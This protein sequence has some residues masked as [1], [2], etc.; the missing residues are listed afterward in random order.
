MLLFSGS[1]P[2]R[3]QVGG[4][5]T[6]LS[7]SRNC[8]ENTRKAGIS[9]SAL[10]VLVLLLGLV[11]TSFTHAFSDDFSS[12]TA[13]NY[14]VVDIW[15]QS[16]V[17]SFAVDAASQ[18]GQILTGDNIGIQVGQSFPAVDTSSFSLDFSPTAIYPSGGIVRIRLRENASTYYEIENTDG[19]GPGTVEKVVGGSVV[20]SGTFG[21]EF[22]FGSSY[23]LTIDFSPT[24]V[25]VSGFGADV[26]VGG[27]STPINVS[28]VEIEFLQL[29][30]FI[31]NLQLGP[32]VPVPAQ[33]NI[34]SPADNTTSG[35]ADVSIA[36]GTQGQAGDFD[37]IQVQLDAQ[38]PISLTPAATSYTFFGLADGA[39]TVVVRLLSNGVALP[40]PE[41]S[42]SVDFDVL[43][44]QAPPTAFSDDFSANTISSYSQVASN[45]VA[46]MIY[47]AA[48]Q[49][50]LL[51][52][53]DNVSLSVTRAFEGSTNTGV[54][55]FEFA[56]IALYP[57]G[58]VLNVRLIQD[59]NNY[60][61][62][63]NTDGYGAGEIEKVVGGVVVATQPFGGE[64][65]I[66]ALYNLSLTFSPTEFH[67]E[68]FGAPV[69]VAGNTTPI[70]VG[71]VEFNFSQLDGYIDDLSL[72]AEI[73]V[74][75]PQVTI[76]QPS[77]GAVLAADDVRV[78]FNAQAPAGSFDEI[79]VQLDAQA[80]VSL[81][82]TQTEY[83]FS[84]VANGAHSVAVRLLLAGAPLGNA[85]ASDSSNFTVNVVPVAP[86]AEAGPNQ[87]VVQGETVNLTS[88]G[89]S[90]DGAIVSYLWRQTAGSENL[91]FDS[92]SATP[93]FTA[94]SV[95]GG[96]EQYTFELTVTDN[97][98]LTGQ[99]TVTVTVRSDQVSFSDDF[100]ANSVA[101]YSQSPTNPVAELIFDS[102][103]QRGFVQTADN[104]ALIISR[105]FGVS[106]DTGV[107]TMD[108]SP[109]ALYPRGA[110]LNLRLVQDANNY[111]E[112]RNT[113]GYGA[114]DIDKVVGG[115]VVASQPFTGEFSIGQNYTLTLTFSPDDFVVG[116]FGPDV[117]A[118]DSAGTS[119]NVQSFEIEF[120]QL[121]G[122]IDNINLSAEIPLPV[123]QVS[124]NQPAQGA[125]LA[126]DSVLVTFNTIAEAGAF[127]EIEVQ[128]DSGTPVSLS[129]MD[130]QYTFANVANGA[131]T[132]TVQ[133][134]LAGTALANVEAQDSVNFNVNVVPLAPTAEAGPNQNVVQGDAVNLSSAG[135]S[136]DGTIVSYFWRQTSGSENLV[137]N[138]A[139][140][141]PSFTA[142]NVS[143]S[144]EQYTF[145]LTVTDNDGLTGQ[146][147]V[148]ITVRS[149]QISFAD[150]FSANSVAQ[151]AQAP[152]N[153]VASLS[154]DGASQRGF[155]QTADN[156]ALTISRPFGVSTD[157]GVFTMDFSPTALYPSGAILNV[158]L[159]QDAN[160]YYEIRNTDGYGPGDIDKVVGG[161]VVASQPFG[162]EFSIGQDYTLTLTFS[163][164]DF[165]VG[166]FGS[167]VSAPD[168]AGTALNVQSFE[169]QFTQMDGFI[170]NINLSAE[171]PLPV[172]QV[173]INQPTPGAT[174]TSDSVRVTFNTIAEAGAFDEIEVQLD[175]G[176]PV[177]LSAM[178]TEH[179]FN[180]VANGAHTI[181]VQ[182]LLAGSALANV[183]A[184]D[185]V[186][187]S[188]NVSAA[189]PT[190]EAG[191][192]QS[193]VQGD[194]VQLDGSASTDNGTI[195][196]YAWQQTAGS[197]VVSFN[198]SA[199]SPTFTAPNVA[200]NES[201]TFQLTVTDNDG[202]TDSDTVTITIRDQASAFADDFS[203]NTI[204]SYSQSS[205][206]P[207]A[208]FT[209]DA[210]R[211]FMQTADNVGLTI[212]R[213]LGT[214]TNFGVFSMEFLPIQTYPAGGIAE[215]RLLQD[216]NN[217]YQ[218]RNTNGYGPGDLRKVVGGVVVDSQPFAAEFALND[219]YSLAL[220]F[221]P[222]SATAF[223]FGNAVTVNSNT[224]AIDVNRF[225]IDFVQL[226][227]Y[228]DNLDLQITQNVPPV[229]MA[230][231]DK[232]T[233]TGATVSFDAS[234]NDLDG[235]VVAYSWTQISGPTAALSNAT[236]NNPSMTA[237]FVSATTDLVYQVV[238][239][240]NEGASS[241]PD[242]VTVKVYPTNG[243]DLIDD[244]SSDTTGNYT[245]T[246]I[247]SLGG[248]NITWNATD[249]NLQ[250][251]T[252]DN[253]A[254]R[255][256]R[257]ISAVTAGSLEMV[258]QPVQSYPSG[259]VITL[260]LAESGNTYYEYE[261]TS[262]LNRG[263]LRK[264]VNGVQVA[265]VDYAPDRP[266]DPRNQYLQGPAYRLK[267][268]FDGERFTVGG[269]PRVLSVG[270]P[271]GRVLNINRIDIEFSQQ[272]AFVD[273]F[274][275]TEG[276][277]EY[278][279]AFGDSITEG[280]GDDINEDGRGYPSI[281]E[282][283]VNASSSDHVVIFNEGIGGNNTLDG[284]RRMDQV[285]AS[286]PA[287]T[288]VLMQLGT[289]DTGALSPI[290]SGLGTTPPTAGSYKDR[291]QSMIDTFAAVGWTPV[292]A[293]AHALPP[294]R[295]NRDVLLQEYNQVVDE[296]IIE[297]GLQVA[298][299]FHCYFGM[300]T[301]LMPD[302]V[303]PDG[304]GY[305][306]QAQIWFNVLTTQSGACAP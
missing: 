133:M 252:G 245:I 271:G 225:E 263:H 169:I 258:V 203:A 157:T 125:T 62:I 58:A 243:Q 39:Y 295:Q 13:A 81:S 151:Y 206:N 162:G 156:V 269:L 42:D 268:Y 97:D 274:R 230:G 166:G 257:N 266:N 256:T 127:D 278:W 281:L 54:F 186:S 70:D 174:L 107:F 72:V 219:L 305:L 24:Q 198:T 25:V 111:Y 277:V 34:S 168:S 76:N 53:A 275:F 306:D 204:S 193:V 108:F 191:V 71:S 129:A 94:P 30:G 87:S 240:D 63:R 124:I 264:F 46:L 109:T 233:E 236:A 272:D 300:N 178:A 215:I 289:N 196:Q 209:L 176:A 49:R 143:G 146:D 116:G 145:E 17:G 171:I 142:P 37:E 61:Q 237:P 8:T 56:P 163:P 57:R 140:A 9:L 173:V 132:I 19:Y 14:S 139:S 189:P 216:D 95:S 288:R 294:P 51:Q 199:A 67:V 285:A 106:T 167:D 172:P 65:S 10:N 101:Q 82:P 84:S 247:T 138:A 303:H 88:A 255:L 250:V 195:V 259:G 134:L 214:T 21:T 113:D 48:A 11:G 165:V 104:V 218:I 164:G 77:N 283:L 50:A 110:I 36:F 47:D 27:N 93:S 158:R 32:A 128:L 144:S 135:S 207:V 241:V 190:A 279:V 249:Q 248:E 231:F 154:F 280:V 102:A 238:A 287:A 100:S 31:D 290:A 148:T 4:L 183:E 170:D 192:D 180:N 73:A 105:P 299:D 28:S 98:G 35:S 200:G 130:T 123:P 7:V 223:G 160:N 45:P 12:N 222:D 153:P 298:P 265:G 282:T 136:D 122:F 147:T 227:G 89:S 202:L 74:P 273:D 210:Q 64:Y 115:T 69:S 179:T 15:T 228:I 152:T 60:Y 114:G 33:V 244:F 181:S 188:V 208:S 229:V 291:M 253:R 185:S 261:T 293:R 117:S 159:V 205:N 18:R 297:N 212:G 296:L 96:S 242:R 232:R 59:G 83:T 41:A 118:P 103:T 235:T 112:I 262:G 187:F 175:S 220:A 29:D 38:A 40:N 66:G 234:A 270:T 2:K 22:A 3:L 52:T 161:T 246:P 182:M 92:A 155:M 226:D 254:I 131:H 99:D 23:S 201:Y 177:S 137:F 26:T 85:E 79:E 121:D 55:S 43:V 213:S 119:I 5:L 86:T 251:T 80:P 284:I 194:T 75:E 217:Y 6:D 44:G 239:I 120:T 184:Q 221:A 224:T 68:G 126:S 260:T 1:N 20:A 302:G 211:G 150:D 292:L 276:L 267:V 149:G 301:Q 16:G 304:Q 141:A 286:H 197:S 78:T 90:D 91:V